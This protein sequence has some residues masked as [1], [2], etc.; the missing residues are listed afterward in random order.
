MSQTLILAALRNALNSPAQGPDYFK[1]PRGS[2]VPAFRKAGEG[3]GKMA[4]LCLQGDAERGAFEEVTEEARKLGC[5]FG[6]CRYF[7][8]TLKLEAF[9]AVTL[10]SE[11][12]D[13]ELDLIRVKRGS[14]GNFELCAE[15]LPLRPTN[16]A[17]IVIGDG[18][19]PHAEPTETTATVFTWYPGR[20]TPNTDLKS[21]TVKLG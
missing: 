19:N 6:R 17:H 21:A 16:V 12:F 15:S 1:R 8:C 20:L 2:Y 9:E 7:R 4:F 14:H 18:N 11:L 13:D 3:E 5:A 10:L